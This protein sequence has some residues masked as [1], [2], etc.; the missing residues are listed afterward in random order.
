MIKDNWAASA[1]C[2]LPFPKH[3][4]SSKQTAVALSAVASLQ[5]PASRN[6]VKARLQC[7]ASIACRELSIFKSRRKL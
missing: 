1:V 4:D 3:R 5:R 2:L 7:G 6:A